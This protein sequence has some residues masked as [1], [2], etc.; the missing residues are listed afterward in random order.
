M[1]TKWWA[2][3]RPSKVV[4]K[5]AL[6]TRHPLLFPFGISSPTVQQLYVESVW[7][8]DIPN[9]Q[10]K[11]SSPFKC[12]KPCNQGSHDSIYRWFRWFHSSQ[13]KNIRSTYKW[14]KKN[15]EPTYLISFFIFLFSFLSSPL[16]SFPILSTRSPPPP[17]L[18][19]APLAM[20]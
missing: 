3:S 15:I 16:L 2:C 10:Y 9:I 7:H 5:I 12:S 17:T 6:W 4:P 14:D 19:S 18:R 20:L 13:K 8:V 11:K 1:K